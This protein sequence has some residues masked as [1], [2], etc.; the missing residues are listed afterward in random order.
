MEAVLEDRPYADI[1]SKKINQKFEALLDKLKRTND[2][3]T[4]NGIPSESNALLENCLADI[5]RRGSV[6]KSTR[7]SNNLQEI[8]QRKTRCNACKSNSYRTDYY[9]YI[10]QRKIIFY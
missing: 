5:K 8:K 6:P 3:A 7:F 2:I 9:A 1:V 4:L 10:N